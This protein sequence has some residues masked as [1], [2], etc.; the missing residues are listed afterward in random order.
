MADRLPKDLGALIKQR[1]ALVA[2]LESGAVPEETPVH[3]ALF[4]QLDVIDRA[5]AELPASTLKDLV[6]KLEHLA[7]LLNVTRG[8]MAEGDID[9]VLLKAILNE[10]R[11]LGDP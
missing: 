1:A 6:I 8:P 7:L 2:R 5:I 4:E 9:T 3:D 11:V 10:A